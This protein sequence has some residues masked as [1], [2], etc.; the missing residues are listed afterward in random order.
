M[1]AELCFSNP[2][3]RLR[4]TKTIDSGKNFES[5]MR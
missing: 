5:S 3:K 1:E 2:K 4:F